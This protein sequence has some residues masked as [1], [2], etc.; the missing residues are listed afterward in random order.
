M[1]LIEQN[2][3]HAILFLNRGEKSDLATAKIRIE[4]L[5]RDLLNLDSMERSSR[6]RETA[7]AIENVISQLESLQKKAEER[8]PI[9]L[10]LPTQSRD[11]YLPENRHSHYALFD[12]FNDG[13][14]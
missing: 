3:N 14:S 12:S 4:E 2:L 10:S 7:H 5:T 9:L 8:P 11:G 6:R 13:A 1:E